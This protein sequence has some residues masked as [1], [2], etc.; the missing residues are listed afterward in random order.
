M[1]DCILPINIICR[2]T[3]TKL[4]SIQLIRLDHKLLMSGAKILLTTENLRLA[5]FASTG[6]TRFISR[7]SVDFCRWNICVCQRPI[8]LTLSHRVSLLLSS[9][10]ELEEEVLCF[11]YSLI[12]ASSYYFQSHSQSTCVTKWHQRA[13]YIRYYAFPKSVPLLLS[14][15]LK[16]LRPVPQICGYRRKEN[17]SALP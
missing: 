5:F 16:I 17:V 12:S 15:S 11:M 4:R 13:A 9:T 14:L 6:R 8:I 7:F 2:F 10:R 1:I 3:T